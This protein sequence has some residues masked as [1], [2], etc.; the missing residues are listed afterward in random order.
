MAQSFH[1]IDNNTLAKGFSSLPGLRGFILEGI[2]ALYFFLVS[3]GSILTRILL[4]KNLGDRAINFT[5]F[6]LSF[7]FY[8][9]FGYL[10]ISIAFSLLPGKL[11]FLAYG[12]NNFLFSVLMILINPFTILMVIYLDRVVKHSLEVIK[13]ARQ[14]EYKYSF[15]R[16]DGIYFENKKKKK[17]WGFTVTDH[18]IRMIYEPRAVL[19]ISIPML[20]LTLFILFQP[21]D[22]FFRNDQSYLGYIV[23]GFF[24]TA[25][26]LTFSAICLFLE[27]LGILFRY[28]DAAFNMLD[29][30]IDMQKILKIKDEFSSNR[31]E[32]LISIKKQSGEL[33]DFSAHATLD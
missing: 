33:D 32:S 11:T 30:D 6:F 18:I 26:A 21:N 13:R 9:I 16:G 31:N 5:G 1:Q 29:G 12:W 3:A 17:F 19:F 14:K 15:Y 2:I 24:T 8:V 23:V 27:E 4:R 10:I 20:I 28:R 25:L 7:I 22:L